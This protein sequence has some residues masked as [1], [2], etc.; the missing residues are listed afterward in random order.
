MIESEVTANHLQQLR[1]PVVT[2]QLI[3]G[4]NSI[5]VAVGDQKV[6]GNRQFTTFAG[7]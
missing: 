3:L 7:W 2:R 4:R 1:K 5:P 6:V